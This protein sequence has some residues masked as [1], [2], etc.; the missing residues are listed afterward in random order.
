MKREKESPELILIANSKPRYLSLKTSTPSL[1]LSLSQNL[2]SSSTKKCNSSF[3]AQGKLSV[4]RVW[5]RSEA[6]SLALKDALSG[7]SS[8]APSS[9]FGEEGQKETLGSPDVDAVLLIL[10]VQA[11]PSVARRALA[12]GKAVLQEKPVAG[13]VAQALETLAAAREAARKSGRDGPLLPVFALAEN[14]RSEPGVL[15]AAEASRRLA[16]PS[17]SPPSSSSPSS[18]SPGSNASTIS[19]VGNMPMNSSNR[20]HGSRWRRDPEGCPGCFLMD[21]SVHFVAALRAVAAAAGLGEPVRVGSRATSRCGDG[22]DLPAPDTLTSWVEY[23][24]G[25]GGEEEEGKKGNGEGGAAAT[26]ASATAATGALSVTFAG[27]V[28]R[29]ALTLDS[30]AGAVE[31][32]RGGYGGTATGRGAG[33]TVAVSPSPGSGGGRRREEGRLF[34]PSEGSR[35][36]SLRS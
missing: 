26:G 10:P 15:A 5:Y 18:S 1:S 28:P 24:G 27:A 25:G 6:S 17:P 11:M 21:S 12:A 32:S 29:F 35:R 34:T 23:G 31:L 13:T 3:A 2:S 14:Y 19:L 9:S 16:S 4:P 7:S 36:S 33:Y 8:P 22:N 20:Y 30:R